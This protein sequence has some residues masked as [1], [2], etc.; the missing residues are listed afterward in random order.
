MFLLIFYF[1]Y[2]IKHFLFHSVTK[3]TNSVQNHT[4]SCGLYPSEDD[5]NVIE[6]YI[7]VY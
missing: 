3:I 5:F 7:I 4:E 6:M 2:I 1:I